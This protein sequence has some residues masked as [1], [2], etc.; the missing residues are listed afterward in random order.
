MMALEWSS[1]A[2][3]NFPYS[4]SIDLVW[5]YCCLLQ[6]GTRDP[7]LSR[8]RTGQQSMYGLLAAM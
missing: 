2:L 7:V 3:T 8:Y 5:P 1:M 6:E 4:Q